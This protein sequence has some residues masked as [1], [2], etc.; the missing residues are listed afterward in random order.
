MPYDASS[1]SAYLESNTDSTPSES[2]TDSS[3]SFT[4]EHLNTLIEVNPETI[5]FEK[6]G[7]LVNI[8]SEF[9]KSLNLLK[10]DI[11]TVALSMVGSYGFN[12]QLL[13]NDTPIDELPE[14]EVEFP[15]D[16]KD[17]NSL[18]LT[19]IEATETS[20]PAC[21]Y[22]EQFS[23]ASYHINEAGT[24]ILTE[25]QEDYEKATD[26]TDT[27]AQN[28]I[29][30]NPPDNGQ[31]NLSQV[32][33]NKPSQLTVSKKAHS[34]PLYSSIG[35]SIAATGSGLALSLRRHRRRIHHE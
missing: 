32:T 5:Y 29:F 34:W 23:T 2:V 19:H 35:L 10:D 6:Q 13:V 27:L 25:K 4:G 11:L 22:N 31:N 7:V 15:V 16:L 20:I 3:T 17:S 14:M 24:Y 9:L 18:D 28:T 8:D 21:N 30:P 33:L 26:S 12:L 1:Q